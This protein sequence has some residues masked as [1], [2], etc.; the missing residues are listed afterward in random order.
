[1]GTFTSAQKSHAKN[2][3]ADVVAWTK[4]IGY[5]HYADDVVERFVERA[6]ETGIDV[7]RIFDAFNDIRNLHAAI[8]AALKVD[9]HV[10]GTLSYTTSPV[11]TLS[12][13]VDF[14]KRLED[15]GCHSLCIKDMSG[16]LRPYEA[17]DL[18]RT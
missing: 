15:L 1:M 6:R 12:T 11:H 9:A 3:A 10:Q 8:R 18:I 2:T 13:W 7:F 17:E 4:L 5:R 14:A 16:L